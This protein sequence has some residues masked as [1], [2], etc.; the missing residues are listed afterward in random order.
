M[1]RFGQWKLI[2][3]KSDW[4]LD[5]TNC[6][7]RA[8]N[9]SKLGLNIGPIP[10]PKKWPFFPIYQSKIPNSAAP[11]TC[12]KKTQRN[13][14]T[15]NLKRIVF[16]FSASIWT[17]C[18]FIWSVPKSRSDEWCY[19]NLYMENSFNRAKKCYNNALNF[20]LKNVHWPEYVLNHWFNL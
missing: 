13:K 15:K 5:F 11:Q 9:L 7:Y 17:R 14:P 18:D 10:N 8:V 3:K 20:V 16:I 4:L 19:N 12:G 1:L 6:T 2:I